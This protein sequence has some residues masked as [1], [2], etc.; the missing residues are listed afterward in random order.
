[1]GLSVR[2]EYLNETYDD[3]SSISLRASGPSS[4]SP[5]CLNEAIGGSFLNGTAA[6]FHPA[7]RDAGCS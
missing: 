5:P 3:S 1:M 6:M 2:G 4:S 7:D